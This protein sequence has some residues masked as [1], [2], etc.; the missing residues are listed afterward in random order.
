MSVDYVLVVPRDL[1]HCYSSFCRCLHV[2]ARWDV[3]VLKTYHVE[4]VA[5]LER[6]S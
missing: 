2:R 6:I 3:Q 5:A 1:L 4:T